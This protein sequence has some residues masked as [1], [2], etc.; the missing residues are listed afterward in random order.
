MQI[1]NNIELKKY[2][3]FGISAKADTF[4]ELKNDDDF[5]EF[6]LHKEQL[7]QPFYILGG[8]NNTLFI[9]DFPGTIVKVSNTGMEIQDIGEHV[10]LKVKAGTPWNEVVRKAVENNL[11][12]I[13]NLIDIPGQAGAAP[14]QN[15]GAYGSEIK[16]TIEQVEYMDLKTGEFH[17]LKNSQCKFTY[18]GSI[19]KN[20]L[21]G[22]V[23][24]KEIVLKLGKKGEVKT[25]YGNIKK[26]LA[27]EGIAKP[28]LRTISQCISKI[29]AA[30]IPDPAK[31]GNAGSFF[32]NPVIDTATY[33]SLK[34]EFPDIPAYKHGEKHFKIAAGWMIEKAGW[35]GKHFGN[36]GVNATQ[37]LV[38]TNRNGKASGK[39]ILAL[40]DKIIED[41]NS[42][43]GIRL[44]PEVNIIVSS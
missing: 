38:L 35:K 22:K 8:G 25:N 26:M 6:F 13:E 4:V 21:K 43:F 9:G 29:R 14:I 42:I 30:K 15:I 7:P 5:P 27:E 40:A 20:E 11:Y 41:V 18:R 10:L 1:F 37:A 3:S 39:E 19:F 34:K 23:L 32:K 44:A 36:A 33:L 2:N 24:V 16:D 12:G 31:T 17:I 28:D